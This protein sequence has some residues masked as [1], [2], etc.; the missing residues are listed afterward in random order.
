MFYKYSYKLLILC[1][2]FTSLIFGIEIGLVDIASDGT[3]AKAYAESVDGT[4]QLEVTDNAGV[5]SAFSFLLRVDYTTNVSTSNFTD[6]G[7][8]NGYW[9]D[10]NPSGLK[11]KVCASRKRKIRP[12]TINAIYN[13]LININL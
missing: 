12:E 13:L 2:F 8:G 6:G 11:P 3:Y 7:S 1:S 10:W 5:Q 9:K 4:I